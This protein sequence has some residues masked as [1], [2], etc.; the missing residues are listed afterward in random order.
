MAYPPAT[1]DTDRTNDTVLADTHPEDHNDV[2]GAVNDVVAELGAAP[3]GG[4]ASLTARLSTLDTT[5]SNK[6]PLDA[7]LTAIAA[8]VTTSYGRSLLTQ[9]DAAA[10]Q[11]TAG[12]VIGTNVQ[13][14]DADLLALAGLTS[15]ADKVPYFTGSGTAGVADFTSYGR[16]LVDDADAATARATLGLVIGTNVQA[17]DA[18]LAALAG[19]TSAADKMPYFTGS[20]TAATTTVTSF[21]RTLLDD[22]DN[23][24]ARNGCAGP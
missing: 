16:S 1:L 12:L 23:T 5:V 10:L 15:A 3:K 4:S 8:L 14:Y 19:L 6:Q 9:A 18:E 24:T 11:S 2:N 7:D 21:A 17:F 13:A 22:T 20:G